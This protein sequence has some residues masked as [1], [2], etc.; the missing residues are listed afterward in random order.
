MDPLLTLQTFG[1]LV[2]RGDVDGAAALFAEDARYEEPPRPPLYGHAAIHAFLADFAARHSAA[3]FTIER[4]LVDPGGDRLA[5]EWRWSYTRNA[6]G[7]R[8]VYEGIA[9]VEFR[10][11]LIAWWRGFSALVP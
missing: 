6:D 3:R 4:A 10:G 7:E 8:R 1:V 11:G 9:I 2:E 5:A